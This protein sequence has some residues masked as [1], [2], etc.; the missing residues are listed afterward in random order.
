MKIN[1]L[2]THDRLDHLQKDQAI[3][4]AQGAEDCLKKNAL[5]LALQQYSPYI[6][7]WAHPRTGE[8]GF[9]KRMLW[10]PRLSRPVPQ[11]NSYLFRAKSNSD[12]LEICWMIPPREMWDQYKKG[13]VTENEIVIWSINEFEHHRKRL[14]VSHP[15]D[16][17]EERQ[18]YIYQAIQTGMQTKRLM[19]TLYLKPQI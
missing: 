13:N 11:T 5:S 2:E 19:D 3:N 6:Y 10:Q 1:R 9:T 7:I 17:P 18:R 4:L 12:I 16:L 8:D 14:E 15:E